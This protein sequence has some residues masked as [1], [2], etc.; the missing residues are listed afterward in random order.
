[1]SSKDAEGRVG[2]AGPDGAPGRDGKVATK[3]GHT[4]HSFVGTTSQTLDHK[5]VRRT[6]AYLVR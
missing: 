1:M 3:R 2:K 6:P 5:I 4:A